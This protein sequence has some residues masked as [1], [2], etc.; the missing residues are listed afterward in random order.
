MPLGTGGLR[1][2]VCGSG[3]TQLSTSQTQVG[4]GG[5]DVLG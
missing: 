2:Q 3:L 1:I 5:G 4:L